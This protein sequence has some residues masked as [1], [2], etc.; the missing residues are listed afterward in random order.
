M[1]TGFTPDQLVAFLLVLIRVGTWVWIAPPFGGKM[2]P[3]LVRVG[4]SIALAVPMTPSAAQAAGTIPT[5][6]GPLVW[7]AVEQVLIGGLLGLVCLTLLSA[8]QSAGS[9]ID[10]VGGFS[11]AQGFDPLLMQQNAVMSR[12]YGLIAGVLLLVTGGYMVLL[13]GFAATFGALP[14]TGTLDLSASGATLSTALS[15]MVVATLQI[16]APIVGVAFLA[17]VAL[18]LMSRVAP[19]LNA[20]ALGFPIKI[21]LTLLLLALTVPMLP[22]A[23][24][25]LSEQAVQAMSAITSGG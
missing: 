3:P 25:G 24:L 12:V 11:M 15:T 5:T 14:I 1:S 10:V 13:Q 20:F 7:A 6:P 22:P 18:G 2:L 19:A 4:V 23:V 16:A 21:G 9:L 8:V 17:D